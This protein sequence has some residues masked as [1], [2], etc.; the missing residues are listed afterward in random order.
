[1]LHTT[2][3]YIR[4]HFQIV[5]VRGDG[6]CMFHAVGFLIG[7]D[8]H[9]L[10]TKVANYFNFMSQ[11]EW[12]K[13]YQKWAPTPSPQE[14]AWKITSG[15][16][17]G[18]LELKILS[19]I[20]NIHIRVFDERS[21]GTV[22]VVDYNKKSPFPVNIIRTGQNHYDALVKRIKRKA[23]LGENCKWAADCAGRTNVCQDGRCVTSRQYEGEDWLPA[24]RNLV[25][26]KAQL[27][28]KCKWATDCAGRTNVCQDG[29]CVTSRQYE[30]KDDWDISQLVRAFQSVRSCTQASDCPRR[31]VC[32]RRTGECV[33]NAEY[34]RRG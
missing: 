13:N 27:G 8:G 5:P 26:Q 6:T 29:R 32:H 31:Q 16:W 4:K 20:K 1:M 19:I 7:E 14:Y 17:G 18:E 21:N 24:F 28:K 12:E 33:S 23:R 11:H 30:N 10:R 25:P 9:H 34:E 22:R 3:N 15:E 2:R